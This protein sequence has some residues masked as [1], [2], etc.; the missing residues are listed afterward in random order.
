[1]KKT[2]E[3]IIIRA[4]E[5]RPRAIFVGMSGGDDSLVTTHWMMTHVPGC[6]VFHANTGIGIERTR[7]FV[8][9]TCKERGWPLVE[10]RA[11][12]DCGQDYDKE[13]IAH[14]FP[15]PALHLIMYSKFKERC[16]RVLVKRHK[17]H[18]MDK[19]AIFTG[20]RRDESVRR[21]GYDG[22]EVEVRGSQIWVNPLY[23]WSKSRFHDYI[24]EHKLKRNPVAE[25]LG[26]SG[27]CLCG[28]FAHLG[29]KALVRIVE[30]ETAERLDALEIKVRAA[31]HNWG[32]EEEPPAGVVKFKKEKKRGQQ[33]MP[34]C[35]GCTKAAV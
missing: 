15:G 17:T 35:V 4:M 23:H 6:Q 9:D 14:G 25:I 34:F 33:F 2:P 22:Q 16:V 19:V 30:P 12:E 18:R 3:Q 32:W 29:E 27:E 7:Q 24:K 20:I 28:A 10:I 1:M 21:M 31:G 5:Y 26:F 11:K 8:R 13:V